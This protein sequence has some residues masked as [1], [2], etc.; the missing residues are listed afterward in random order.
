MDSGARRM[1]LVPTIEVERGVFLNEVGDGGESGDR[2][3]GKGGDGE[4]GEGKGVL[5]RNG[6]EVFKKWHESSAL[7]H[8][9]VMRT[10][11]P[12][13]IWEGW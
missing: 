10:V 11:I 6:T 1:F 13:E 7:G 12:P 8:W 3:S 2:K 5:W 4:D 9:G